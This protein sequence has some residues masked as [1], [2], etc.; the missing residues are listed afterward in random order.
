MMNRTK[1]DISVPI[2]ERYLLT[3]EEAAEYFR[4]GEK[5]LRFILGDNPGADFFLRNGNRFLIKRKK[6]EIFLDGCE[7]I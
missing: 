6:F 2:S 3:I 4:I 1:N 5:K 7:S